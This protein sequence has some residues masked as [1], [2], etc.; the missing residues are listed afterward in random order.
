MGYA[1]KD[2]LMIHL[3]IFQSIIKVKVNLEIHLLNHLIV[4]ILSS[5]MMISNS[6]L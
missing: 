3:K 2:Y 6:F 1:I 5:H 4:R